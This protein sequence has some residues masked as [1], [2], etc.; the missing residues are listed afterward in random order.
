VEQCSQLTNPQLEIL[1]LQKNQLSNFEQIKIVV[2]NLTKLK[3]LDL[4]DNCFIDEPQLRN[5]I[6]KVGHALEKYNN[7]N[8]K[9]IANVNDIERK[10]KKV[11]FNQN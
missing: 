7:E 8:V 10:E 6:L 3:K 5:S 2:S 11:I 9:P 4:R 1:D